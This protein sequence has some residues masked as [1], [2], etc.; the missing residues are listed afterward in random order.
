M[1]R[2]TDGRPPRPS[3]HRAAVAA[4]AAA[5]AAATS[6]RRAAGGGGRD[7]AAAPSAATAGDC[8]SGGC[9]DDGEGDVAGAAAGRF[10][11]APHPPPPP[12]PSGA[13]PHAARRRA[14]LASYPA[15]AALATPYSPTAALTVVLVA[16]QLGLAV[17][18]P[19]VL[20][21]WAVLV[22][23]YAGGAVVDFSLWAALHEAT[24]ELVFR[25]PLANR[26]VG[27]AA[28]TPHLFPAA[29]LFRHHHRLHHGA[30]GR[31]G[32]DLDMPLPGEAA[33]VG[34]SPPRK[35]AWLAAFAAVQAVRTAAAAGARPLPRAEWPWLAANWAANGGV[36]AA[37]AAAG[38]WRAV[39]Y[40]A[41]ASVAAVGL[42]PVGARGIAEHYPVVA[43]SAAAPTRTAAT[44]KT[45]TRTRTTTT[46]TTTSAP[47][48]ATFQAT[49][50]Y[51]GRANGVGL[52]LGYHVE[53]HDFPGV[54]WVSLPAVRRAA[55]PHYD[56]L[57]H[58]T[59]YTRLL[60]AFVTDRGWS[61]EPRL[62]PAA[63]ARPWGMQVTGGGGG[64]VPPPAAPP[65]CSVRRS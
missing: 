12:P 39:A 41:V 1:G 25:S 45:A 8:A 21:T 56:A 10:G 23:A 53:H 3:L 33:W 36:A 50:S 29:T 18:L 40:L 52:N 15:V 30:L 22:A 58:Y 16:A 27:L 4:A 63:R 59:S 28:N 14:I 49:Y 17:T 31:P 11:A 51:Y 19:R 64:G 61:L 42:H 24:H 32:R 60:W 2:G 7:A 48:A 62:A 38:G 43:P 55:A 57:F 37:V 13:H 35:A 34:G 9:D 54:P 20:P 26:L 6:R 5:A 47:A 44:L 46:T 65:P